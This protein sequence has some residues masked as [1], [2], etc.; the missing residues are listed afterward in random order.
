[1]ASAKI[2]ISL[3]KEALLRLDLLV[4]SGAAASRSK[5]IQEAIEEK[6]RRLDPQRLARE[7]AKLDRRSEQAGA[8]EGLAEDLAA[9]P[10]Y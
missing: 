7:C 3:D 8:D 4:A 10:P 5:L 6:L 9:W 2:A 1:M